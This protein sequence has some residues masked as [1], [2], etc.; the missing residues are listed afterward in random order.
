MPWPIGDKGEKTKVKKQKGGKSKSRA[1]QPR[2]TG[3]KG[4]HV[5]R[6]EKRR[7]GT[8]LDSPVFLAQHAGYTGC[9]STANAQKETQSN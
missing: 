6:E 8:S 4:I 1:N 9:P 7:A 5:K 2:Q 3:Q